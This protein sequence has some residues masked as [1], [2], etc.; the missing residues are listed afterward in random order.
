MDGSYRYKVEIL[1]T[2]YFTPAG[3]IHEVF[4]SR[5]CVL[6]ASPFLCAQS[7]SVRRAGSV[8]KSF[9]L[10]SATSLSEKRDSRHKVLHR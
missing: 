6:K 3:L 7:F 2:S 8:T 10:E 5:L 9:L 1:L 4:S